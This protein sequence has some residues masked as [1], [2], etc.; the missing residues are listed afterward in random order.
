[1]KSLQARI[2]FFAD[3]LHMRILEIEDCINLSGQV[4]EMRLMAMSEQVEDLFE[5]FQ[6]VFRDVLHGED[7]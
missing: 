6:E 4:E 3:K 7:Y 1:M 2:Q 5:D